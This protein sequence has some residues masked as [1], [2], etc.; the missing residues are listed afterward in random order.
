MFWEHF[1]KTLARG[2]AVVPFPNPPSEFVAIHVSWV[3]AGM[4]LATIAI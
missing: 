3:I 4:L 2:Y 1:I